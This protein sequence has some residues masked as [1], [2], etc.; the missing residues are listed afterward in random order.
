MSAVRIPP[1]NPDA[2]AQIIGGLLIDPRALWRCGAL[3]PSD[4][5]R[6]DHRIILDVILRRLRAGEVADVLTVAADLTAMGELD[7]VG[8]LAYLA[9]VARNVYSTANLPAYAELVREAA[10][11]REIMRLLWEANSAID[12]QS[13]ADVS[14]SLMG[15][16][17]MTARAGAEDSDWNAAA[18]AADIDIEAAA[19]SR[20]AGRA[21]GVS[22]TLPGLDKAL[23]GF[24]GGRMYVLG[25]RPGRFKSV[26][27]MQAWLRGGIDGHCVG[28]VSLEMGA[29]EIVSRAYANHYAVNLQGILTGDAAAVR[30]LERAKRER[31][32]KLPVRIDDRAKTL[33]QIRAR[34]MEWKHLHDCKLAIIDHIQLVKTG[35]SRR[36]DELAEI[37][38]TLKGV[39]MELDM[40][41]LVLSQISREVEKEKR[42]PGLSDLRECGNIEQDADCVFFIHYD[43]L[44]NKYELLLAKNRGGPSGAE[45]IRLMVRGEHAKVGEMQQW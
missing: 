16:L 29:A 26:L 6:R 38:S 32:L 5:Y 25:G 7:E 9:E 19:E 10:R 43:A 35:A 30:D 40:P 42:R 23:G 44:E 36:F 1:N 12:E 39:A 20:E 18:H 11:K 34:L 4:A 28:L 13:S 22:T 8:G 27:A 33:T 3:E 24:R 37:S 31:P 21:L 41:I 14:L 17:A 15:G 2:E 45:P